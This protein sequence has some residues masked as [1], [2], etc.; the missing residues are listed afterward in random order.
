[1]PRLFRKASD[2]RSRRYSKSRCRGPL[3]RRRLI[4]EP[5]ETRWLLD[6]GPL[7][8]TE[9]MAVNDSTLR[10]D[11]GEY[12]DWIEIFNPTNEAVD[13]TGWY[14]TDNDGDLRK[15]AF[16]SITLDANEYMVVFASDKDRR[17]PSAPLHTNFKLDGDEGEY[18]ALVKPDG[19]G[20]VTVAFDYDPSFPPQVSD[21]SY[22]IPG[23]VTMVDD[24]TE[25]VWW[26]PSSS[27]ATLGTGWTATTFGDVN[28]SGKQPT[29]VRIAEMGMGSIDYLEIQNVS[30]QEV[31]TS[32]WMVVV[33]ADYRTHINDVHALRWYLPDSI[34]AGAVLWRD[35]ADPTDEYYIGG[36]LWWQQDGPGWAMILDDEGHVVDFA[37]WN[38][39][40]AELA[41]FDVTIEG[42]HITAGGAWIGPAVDTGGTIT[43]LQRY[44]QADTNT[45]ADFRWRSTSS[46]GSNNIGLVRPF[47]EEATIGFSSYTDGLD[48]CIQTD[49]GPDM[50]DQNAS[51]W[52]RYTFQ[53]D[54]P[55]L[56]DALS[57]RLR[58]NDGFVAFLNGQVIASANAP[59]TLAWNSTAT[60][61]RSAAE[62]VEFSVIDVTAFRSLLLEGKNVLAIQGLNVADGDPT[63]LIEAQLYG[64]PA[65]TGYRYF[66]EPTPGD[67]NGVGSLS[68]GDDLTFS[69]LG[70]TFTTSFALTLH[71][72]IPG[73][74]IRYTFDRTVPTETSTLYTGPISI[75]TTTMV[76]ARVIVPG[77]SPGI[78]VSHT[79]FALDTSVAQFNSNIPLVVV[80]T[81]GQGVNENSLTLTASA[82]MEVG[83]DGRA[84]LSSAAD[85]SGQAG[86]KIRGSSSTSFPKKQYA[87]ELWDEERDDMAASL[88]GL[89]E[90]SDWV[91]YGPYSDKSLIRN[92]L[93]YMWSNRI[94]QYA[95]R[96]VLCEMYLDL[97]GGKV[98]SGDYVGVYVLVEKIKLDENRVDIEKLSA[99]QNSEPEISGGYIFKKDRLDPG[100]TGFTTSRGQVFGYVEPK[101]DEIS[102]EQ[103]AWLTN[104]INAFE[105]ALYGANYRDP[106]VGYAAYIDVDSFIDAHILVELTKNIDGYRLSSFYYKDRDGKLKMGPLWD[107]NLSLGNANYLD[108][109]LAEGF[110]YPLI[111]SGEYPYF[112]RLFQDP[113]FV[114]RYIDR[115]TELRQD[116]FSNERLLGDIDTLAALL[117]ESA[118]R[119]FQR[120]PI[121]GT[122]VW[123]NWFIADTYQEE[124]DF[125]KDWL[126]DRLAWWDSLYLAAPEF[127]EPSGPIGPDFELEI[128]GGAG[129]VYYT[130][131]GSDPRLPGG[132]ISPTAMIAGG[133]TLDTLLPTGSLW[134]YND[135]GANLGTAWREPGA[136]YDGWGSGNAELGYGDGDETTIVSYGPNPSQKYWTT[137][138]VT[139]FQVDDAS[140]YSS[141]SLDL[142]YDDGAVVYINGQEVVRANMPAG[143]I[144]YTTPASSAVS[145]AAEYTYTT[146]ALNVGVLQNGVN[147][148]AVEVHQRT[149]NSTDLS[150]NLGL[151]AGRVETIGGFEEST[152][153][154]ARSY[155][156]GSWSG[157][158]KG[159]YLIES[160]LRVSELMINPPAPT[161]AE[162]LEGYDENDLFEFIELTNTGDTPIDLSR[163]LL[164]DGVTFDFS[165]GSVSTLNPGEYA[166][167]VRDIE[168]FQFRYPDVP[169]SAIAGVFTGALNNAGERV[170]I[171]ANIGI[172]I[173]D[174]E[175]DD[176]GDWPW[177]AE[178]RGSSLELIDPGASSSDP[179]NW[180]ASN[181]WGGTPGAAPTPL[182]RDVV[183]NEILANPATGGV[184]KIELVNTAD[185]AVDISGWYLSD[186][187]NSFHKFPIPAGTI[188]APGDCV[189]FDATQFNASGGVDPDDFGLSSLGEQVWLM[190]ADSQGRL[191]RF[192]DVVEFGATDVGQSLGRRPNGTGAMQPMTEQTF[193]GPNSAVAIGPILITE[194]QYH[195]AGGADA[196]KWEYI[197]LFNTTDD[198]VD[199]T[200]WRI[201]GGVD[202]DFAADTVIPAGG[203]LVLTRIDPT[204]SS[205]YVG[206]HTFYNPGVAVTMAGPF[207]G[208]LDNGGESVR[209]L[210]PGTPSPEEPDTTPY[211]LVDQASYDDESPWPT[212]PDGG[213]ATLHRATFRASGM[214]ESG[215]TVATPSP[216]VVS[217]TTSLLGRHLFY[218]GSG[219]DDPAVPRTDD[220]AIAAG[221]VPLATGQQA[222]YEN[223]SNFSGGIT[224]IMIDVG[225]LPDDA[226]PSAADFVFRVGNEDDTSVWTAAPAP[227]SVAL[228]RGEG[229][230]GAD[231][232]VVTWPEG[233]IRNTWLQVTVLGAGLGLGE[234]SVFYWGN[235]PGET[236][237]S[238]TH[239]LVNATDLV[240]LRGH[241]TGSLE[242]VAIASPHDVNRD[243]VVDATDFVLTRTNV[244]SPLTAL[245]LI[246][247]MV[248]PDAACPP[249]SVEQAS[250]EEPTPLVAQPAPP[251]PP[252]TAAAPAASD[253]SSA[254]S[255]AASVASDAASASA[256]VDATPAAAVSRRM[257]PAPERDEALRRMALAHVAAESAPRRLRPVFLHRAIVDRLLI[258]MDL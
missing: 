190:E 169:T 159:V 175:Y 155:S 50:R 38:Y 254:A 114:Q 241:Y 27:D 57:L 209:L 152:M 196:A 141:L 122:Y 234:D 39:T 25:P 21:V 28:W 133:A 75:T 161:P 46:K 116:L 66:S 117:G 67:P 12:R 85:F 123:P 69:R 176:T 204:N 227:Q 34:A 99:G 203:I 70:G 81:F 128:T 6:A 131:D 13:L 102:A 59:E 164:V 89:P 172:P 60:A 201:R 177:R 150:F 212:E 7:W 63:F 199:L 33:N 94:G 257:G 8:I 245:K 236:G 251:A 143:T 113:D 105:T 146:F 121:L 258:A 223:Y 82:F 119:N 88:L 144:T 184:D 62:S 90:E 242:Y 153:V 87:F 26:V 112:G 127:S 31:D 24:E 198:E 111:S 156:G 124:I 72:D 16:P 145:G 106:E 135:T 115:W 233:A 95:P 158:T 37:A 32:G 255:N 163:L 202:F 130:L 210:R 51:L 79:Y 246:T 35:D 220:L 232:I 178:G 194:I 91:L 17:D 173:L 134:L 148:I 239:A 224:G 5:L 100:D 221:K 211:F 11:D 253:A 188:L 200:G 22:G 225:N 237:D 182:V 43:S 170:A 249:A 138:F 110:Y 3:G 193:G 30:S 147:L 256:A 52:T 65:A 151:S 192:G 68:L 47:L 195:P 2:V 49:V 84:W 166:V 149:A 185:Y 252:A 197:E 93:S 64:D 108:G 36:N 101:E 53:L 15:W 129:T 10:D 186:S 76:R 44:G 126:E 218:D 137:Y 174:L 244:T 248:P 181:V 226:V 222:S 139:T 1:M 97:N 157:L 219:L 104:Y 240:A 187:S 48:I 109:W 160:K 162:R 120:W 56:I 213:G 168:A 250:G 167:V 230:S 103:T 171:E 118:A 86:L 18:L 83:A 4:H 92:V 142:I 20:G 40:E 229:D 205:D 154:K 179:N 42:F 58:Y 216:G 208:V 41:S 140:L 78:V 55:S 180:I 189:V 243:R 231:R 247:P 74:E 183:V 98:T 77:Q 71:T 214:D 228:R 107:Y 29:S 9:L 165:A 45:A 61:G 23:R 125:M 73:A 14:L 136:S 206:F 19:A 217:M 215:W 238:A 191:G 54:D 96:T 207:E 80:S 132:A 235:A